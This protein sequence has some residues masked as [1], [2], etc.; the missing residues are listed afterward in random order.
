MKRS[1]PAQWLI[2][3]FVYIL[4]LFFLAM[5][6]SLSINAN[7]GISPV[8]S[9]PYVVSRISGLAMSTCVILIFSLYILLQLLLLGREFKW[10]N[11]TQVVFSVIFG[12]FVDFGKW[13]LGEFCLPGYGGRLVMLVISILLVA[14]GLTLYIETN[15]MPMPMEGL[16]LAIAGKWDKPFPNVK[17]AVDCTVVAVGLILSL[18]FLGRLDGIR[19]GTIIA[20]IVTGK[21]VALIKK[22]L[23]PFLRRIC[24]GEA[25]GE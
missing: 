21:V 12:Y 10:I 14:V 7:L 9:L 8:N 20:A 25:A 23:A 17:I 6:A 18:V 19:E 11:L 5:G 2:R 24:F 1:T 4:G 16:T 15:L 22:P 3:I 13:I